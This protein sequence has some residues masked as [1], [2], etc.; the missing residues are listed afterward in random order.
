MGRIW[1]IMLAV[2]WAKE[3]KHGHFVRLNRPISAWRADLGLLSLHQRNSTNSAH[4]IPKFTPVRHTSLHAK[5]RLNVILIGAS[6]L[7]FPFFHPKQ[8]TRPARLM[9]G[10]DA[11][12]V[13]DQRLWNP[14]MPH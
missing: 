14:K 11:P 1:I 6:L 13:R 8:L 2:E 9:R 3:E 10:E 5:R 4:L 12:I 7:D